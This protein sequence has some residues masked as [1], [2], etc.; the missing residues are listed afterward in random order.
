MFLSWMVSTKSTSYDMKLHLTPSCE[1]KPAELVWNTNNVCHNRSSMLSTRTTLNITEIRPIFYQ[2]RLLRITYGMHSRPDILAP[3]NFVPLN[4]RRH[5]AMNNSA[6]PTTLPWQSKVPYT[7]LK[8]ANSNW[9]K[10]NYWYST[11]RLPGWRIRK[12]YWSLVWCCCHT[13]CTMT[14]INNLST[15]NPR[16]SS[17]QC[18]VRRWLDFN[19]L[20]RPAKKKPVRHNNFLWRLQPSDTACTSNVM[21]RSSAFTVF[22]RL[23]LKPMNYRRCEDINAVVITQLPGPSQ[24]AL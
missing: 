23:I 4:I 8:I 18:L 3:V 1:Y 13:S 20:A 9:M 2:C 15:N 14:S 19:P 11:A 21:K 10:L 17:L 24:T 7:A 16:Q 22:E 6:E 5:T 12:V